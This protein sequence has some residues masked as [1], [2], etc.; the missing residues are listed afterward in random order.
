MSHFAKYIMERQ[1]KHILENRFGFATYSFTDNA[2]YIEEIY[3]SEE[4]RKSNRAS[5][6]A[7]KICEMAKL[8][9]INLL[10]GSVSPKASGSTQSIQVLLAY[11]MQLDSCTDNFILLRKAI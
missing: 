10:Y 6:M 9:G 1:G 2:V 3:V 7:D 4:H 5:E 11:G 8:R